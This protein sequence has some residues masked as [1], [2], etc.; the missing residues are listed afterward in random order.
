MIWQRFFNA[1]S[2]VFGAFG[3]LADIWA[4]SGAVQGPLGRQADPSKGS[5][6]EK[7][8]RWTP[9]PSQNE[10]IF[11]LIFDKY[12]NKKVIDF[13]MDFGKVFSLKMIPKLVL[14]PLKNPFKVG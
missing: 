3:S 2:Y 10:V 12:S 7:L 1:F 14:K 13:G 11:A 6:S 9:A 5:G 4:S 8:V